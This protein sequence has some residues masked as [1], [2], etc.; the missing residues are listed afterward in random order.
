MTTETAGGAWLTGTEAAAILGP[1][2]R[3]RHIRLA[4]E[5]GIIPTRGL[6]GVRRRYSRESILRLRDYPRAEQPRPET[7]LAGA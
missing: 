5:R 3:P 6:P 1:D 7:C 2:I 4:A